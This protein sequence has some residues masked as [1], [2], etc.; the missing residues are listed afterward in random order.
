MHPHPPDEIIAYDK[1]GFTRR[2][3]IPALLARLLLDRR[4]TGSRPPMGGND[5]MPSPC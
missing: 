1:R 2:S 5:R 4:Q 3:I